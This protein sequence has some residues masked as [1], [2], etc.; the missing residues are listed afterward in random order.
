MT[1]ESE[2]LEFDMLNYQEDDSPIQLLNRV[3]AIGKE[4]LCEN[5]C[6]DGSC[7]YPGVFITP[8]QESYDEGEEIYVKL[9]VAISGLVIDR[10]YFYI[11][12]SGA[13]LE[14]RRLVST[15]DNFQQASIDVPNGLTTKSDIKG[16]EVSLI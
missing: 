8:T 10:L 6:N 15:L 11:A 9:E 7:F 12:E 2:T 5:G 16:T 1:I 13:G 4:S 3:F 14:G